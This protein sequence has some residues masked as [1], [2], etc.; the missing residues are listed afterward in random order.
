[1]SQDH[2]RLRV[3]WL[4]KVVQHWL[5]IET[6]NSFVELNVRKCMNKCVMSKKNRIL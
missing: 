1:M 5:S 4:E 3:P 2:P 6:V